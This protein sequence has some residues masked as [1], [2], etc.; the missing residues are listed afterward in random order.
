MLQK[1]IVDLFG[2]GGIFVVGLVLAYVIWQ[3]G[4]RMADVPWLLAFAASVIAVGG[5]VIWQGH[6]L[7]DEIRGNELPDPFGVSYAILALF[8]SGLI[9]NAKTFWRVSRELNAEQTGDAS[10]TRRNLQIVLEQQGGSK[11]A[12]GEV[13]E[14]VDSQLDSREDLPRLIRKMLPTLG[15]VGTVIGL[16]IAMNELGGALSKAVGD[17]GGGVEDLMHSMQG[18]LQGMGGAF[19]TTLLGATFGMLLMVLSTR[20]RLVMTRLIV[21]AK[22]QLDREGD[23]PRQQRKPPRP[24][25]GY[26]RPEAN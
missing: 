12:D 8:V 7:T 9:T 16:A 1:L 25:R 2:Q 4:R 22:R 6:L 11:Q 24:P 10:T 13:V 14:L 26:F 15:L 20:T 23:Q 3:F 18:A 5:C 17:Q 21:E 19:V